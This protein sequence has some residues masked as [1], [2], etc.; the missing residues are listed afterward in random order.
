MQIRNRPLE[1]K[2]AVVTGASRGVGKGVAVALGEAGALVYATGR[3]LDPGTSQWPG[4]LQETAGEI[5]RRG[6][7]CIPVLCDHA[8]DHS[9][10]RVFERVHD[11]QDGRIDVLVNNVFAAPARMPVNVP[12]WEL[13]DEIWETLLRVGLRSHYVASRCAAPRMVARR[14]G[15]IV[16]TSS[17][18]AVRYTFN[19]PFGV[20]KAGVDKMAKDMAHDLKPFNVAAVVIW[21]GFIKS[22]KFLAQPERMPPALA[23]RIMENGESPEFA[24]R[25]V[26]G[27]AADSRIMEKTGQLH[28]VAEL[29]EEYGFTDIDGR[30]PA[31]PAR[32]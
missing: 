3:T 10:K 29:A 22:E 9:V 1:G 26:A 32:A 13:D 12:F 5:A 19:V 28:L 7:T 24:G 25:A 20:Q 2:V 21:P 8:D 14:Q 30:M 27:L 31:K 15:L 11:E 17:G 23:Q 4:S 16:N 18:G 6:G